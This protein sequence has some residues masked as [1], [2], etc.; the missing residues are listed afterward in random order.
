MQGQG[1]F[2]YNKS[3][4]VWRKNGGGRVVE[5]TGEGEWFPITFACVLLFENPLL[6]LNAPLTSFYIACRY[7]GHDLVPHSARLH[8]WSGAQ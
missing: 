8:A 1:S 5:I 7:Q 3:G 2:K 6:A 4:L